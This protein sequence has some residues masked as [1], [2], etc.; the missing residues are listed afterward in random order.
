MICCTNDFGRLP[1]PCRRIQNHG[2]LSWLVCLPVR[3][4]RRRAPAHAFAS[5]LGQLHPGQDHTWKTEYR[6]RLAGRSYEVCR[7]GFSG[8]DYLTFS[9][10]I[11]SIIEEYSTFGWELQ[12]EEVLSGADHCEMASILKPCNRSPKNNMSAAIGDG[13][14]PGPSD[15]LEAAP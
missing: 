13:S 8:R 4:G 9:N 10:P 2:A 12:A 11:A 7:E 3:L 14:N 1:S 15:A 5:S 6:V